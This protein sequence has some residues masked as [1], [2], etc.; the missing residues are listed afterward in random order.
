MGNVA[1]AVSWSGYFVE[2]LQGPRHHDSRL[3][4]DRPRDGDARRRDSWTPRRIVFGLPIV[5]NLPAAAITLLL[6]VAA[7]H[8]HQGVRALQHRDGRPQARDPRLLHR[9][10]RDLRQA[11]QLAPVRAERLDR[12]R[13]RRGAH[14]LRLHRLRRRLDGG[15]GVR[16][17]A[18]RHA[19]RHD[20]LARD[21]HRPLR[22][23]L[24]RPD[25]HGAARADPG[26]R[27]SRSP[28][29]SRFSG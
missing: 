8:R 12:H 28:R 1:V 2:L 5:L 21:L 29:P 9:R 20:R 11:R 25:G 14:L 13:H 17:P 7:R 23:D 24:A 15:R 4:V 10:R 22:R 18:A 27:P 26:L 6:T 3:D 19:D 16:E